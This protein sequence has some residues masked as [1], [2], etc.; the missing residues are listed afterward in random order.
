MPAWWSLLREGQRA[1]GS[2]VLSKGVQGLRKLPAVAAGAAHVGMVAICCCRSS[3]TGQ[4]AC[5]LVVAA[6]GA[7]VGTE[8][9]AGRGGKAS[10][11]VFQSS[12]AGEERVG[13]V[14]IC[15]RRASSSVCVCF[16]RSQQER[17]MLALWRSVVA[18][19]GN[20]VTQPSGAVGPRTPESA[21]RLPPPGAAWRMCWARGRS[22]VRQVRW[23]AARPERAAAVQAMSVFG[24]VPLYSG[25]LRRPSWHLC[26]L[27]GCR[28]FPMCCLGKQIPG[29]SAVSAKVQGSTQ[30]A[31][32][33]SSI[34]CFREGAGPRVRGA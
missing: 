33:P 31:V 16:R 22:G 15:C 34:R 20:L 28:W 5:V 27:V 17:R 2:D 9:V 24:Y 23:L 21:S 6:G 7:S 32:R 10:L 8:A 4:S 26:F 25:C 12:S 29:A 14:G 13:K 3:R 1:G 19:P 30:W 18:G 11:S